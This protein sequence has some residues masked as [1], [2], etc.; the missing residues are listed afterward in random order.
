MRRTFIS[1]LALSVLLL[2]R[3]TSAQSSGALQQGVRV[4]IVPQRG[5]EKVGRVVAITPDTI[6]IASEGSPGFVSTFATNGIR[7]LDKSE[8]V[9]AAQ[10]A[11]RGGFIGLLVGGAGGFAIMHT[12]HRN[13]SLA[14][15][16]GALW[17]GLGGVT[18]GAS[19]GAV[20][21]MESWVTLGQPY[22][23]S[24]PGSKTT[25]DDPALK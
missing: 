25:T 11:L 5:E 19:L 1:I 2:P 7:R 21:G 17:G 13:D 24:S 16:A 20:N 9:S 10:G 8:G 3:A 18:V 14:G 15:V 22:V 6:Q 23:G 4:R 12:S